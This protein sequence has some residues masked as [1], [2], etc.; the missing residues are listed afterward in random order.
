MQCPSIAGLKYPLR[1]VHTRW[2][3]FIDRRRRVRQRRVCA[4]LLQKTASAMNP[5][6]SGGP[7][8][9][10]PVQILLST[11]PYARLTKAPGTH[12]E[13]PAALPGVATFALAI[14]S[15]AVHPEDPSWANPAPAGSYL[16]SS[17]ASAAGT[18]VE[19]NGTKRPYV[20]GQSRQ[21]HPRQVHPALRNVGFTTNV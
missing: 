7:A 1:P 17:V 18:E 5:S 19:H 21:S 10:T 3:V 9:D 13:I 4:Q 11:S 2:P 6:G 8:C 15:V 12:N 20:S 14:P 16:S